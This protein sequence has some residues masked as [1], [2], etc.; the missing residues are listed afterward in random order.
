M[1][2]IGNHLQ[3]LAQNEHPRPDYHVMEHL[4]KNEVITDEDY[5]YQIEYT[6]RPSCDG[7]VPLGFRKPGGKVKEVETHDL[8]KE[9][10]ELKKMQRKRDKALSQGKC[11]ETHRSF[12]NSENYS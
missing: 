8:A 2:H 12:T 1:V 9:R 11:K 6:E 4:W 10:R 7:L 3:N 5:R